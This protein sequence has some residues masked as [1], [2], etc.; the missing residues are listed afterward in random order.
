MIYYL[1]Q[2]IISI[3]RANIKLLLIAILT[4]KGADSAGQM[5]LTIDQLISF[6]CFVLRARIIGKLTMYPFS[7]QSHLCIFTSYLHSVGGFYKAAPFKTKKLNRLGRAHS[8]IDSVLAS[9]PAAPGSILGIPKK[10][11]PRILLLLLPRFIDGTSLLSQW[12]VEKLN[13]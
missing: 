2:K 7:N 4:I 3:L 13:S 5:Y 1:L 12:A 9:H 10:F 6:L 8:T 11:S